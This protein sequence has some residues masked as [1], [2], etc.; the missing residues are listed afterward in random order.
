MYPWLLV[1]LLAADLIGHGAWVEVERNDPTLGYDH[2]AVIE[3]LRQQPS[4][5]RMENTASAWAPDAAARLGLEDIGGISNPLALAA[6]QTYLGAVGER[7]S[8]LYDFLNAQF[9]VA[10]KGQPP[11]RA[12]S[13]LVPVFDLDPQL[14]V[15][16]NTGVMPRVSLV[17]QSQVVFSGEAAFGALHA[18]GFDPAA[19][20]VVDA[21]SVPGGEP[22]AL[23]GPPAPGG[24]LYYLEYSPERQV[25]AARTEAPAYLVFSEVWYPGWEARIGG[26]PVPIWRA[27]F[28]FRAVYLPGAG[29]Y[30]VTLQ[31]VSPAWRQGAALT[32]LTLATLA[33]WGGLAWRRRRQLEP[34]S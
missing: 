10:D 16:L 33:G 3:F 5:T 34:G 13:G 31:F 24:N 29:D 19:A 8:P 12:G 15:Y 14:D 9:V 17:Y 27:N 1:G 25:V 28:A 21:S 26:Q 11:A 23:N 4:P 30:V 32:G 2:P 22:A 18:A 6:Y 20:V 7:G